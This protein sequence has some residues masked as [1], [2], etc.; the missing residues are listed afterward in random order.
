MLKQSSKAKRHV[1]SERKSFTNEPLETFESRMRSFS[2]ED[3]RPKMTPSKLLD[4][5]QLSGEKKVVFD[6]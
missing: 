2:A 6:V 4:F 5:S 3:F 1:K